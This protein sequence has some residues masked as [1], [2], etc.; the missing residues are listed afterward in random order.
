[1]NDLIIKLRLP[2]EEAANLIETRFGLVDNPRVIQYRLGTLYQ[3]DGV[4]PSE[5]YH[6]DYLLTG[7]SDIPISWRPYQVSPNFPKH[8]LGGREQDAV[9]AGE[10][11]PTSVADLSTANVDLLVPTDEEAA[12]FSGNGRTTDL[13]DAAN[14]LALRLQIIQ[15]RLALESA[16]EARDSDNAAIDTAQAIIDNPA[17]TN[18]EKQAAR[19]AKADAQAIIDDSNVRIGLA[20]DAIKTAQEDKLVQLATI[21]ALRE[22]INTLKSQRYIKESQW[23]ILTQSLQEELQQQSTKL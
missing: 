4:T 17:S 22:E 6:M 8:A 19:N 5:G 20:N 21:D 15:K 10:L 18:V 23:T 14:R 11:A 16:K 7:I 1:M 13:V 12:E 3:E 9:A 2:S